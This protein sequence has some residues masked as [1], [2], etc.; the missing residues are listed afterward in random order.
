[1]S[2]CSSGMCA[3][4]LY[5]SSA[6]FSFGLFLKNKFIGA[7]C[8]DFTFNKQMKKKNSLEDRGF[9]CSGPLTSVLIYE[10]VNLTSQGDNPTV[11]CK[12]S[13]EVDYSFVTS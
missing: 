13:V 5:F 8:V 12:N 7:F 10:M 9:Q 1:M 11:R 2:L 6:H 3:C 4:H